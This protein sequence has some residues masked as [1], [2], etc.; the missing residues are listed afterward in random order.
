MATRTENPNVTDAAIKRRRLRLGAV[1]AAA[2]VVAFVAWL[3]LKDDDNG[4][5]KRAKPTA[6]S[7]SDLQSVSNSVGHPI[8]W[9]GRR[10]GETYELTQTP[11]GNVYIRY[12]PAG[13]EIGAPRPDYLTVGTYPFPRAYATLQRLARKRDAVS[14]TIPGNGLVVSTNATARNAYFAYR[15]QEL[16][17]EVYDP[18]PGRAIRLASSGQI[19]PVR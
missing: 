18:Q 7:V 17:V 15:G 16:Q 8:Y 1:L 14:R 11:G 5:S 10:A 3:I 12:L 9:A 2:V 4:G 13:S 19:K 6:A